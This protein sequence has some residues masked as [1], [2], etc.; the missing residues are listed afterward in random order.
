MGA[1]FLQ[2]ERKSFN[3]LLLLVAIFA[4]LVCGNPCWGSIR[5]DRPSG[6]VTQGEPVKLTVHLQDE[7]PLRVDVYYRVAGFRSYERISF[8]AKGRET[9]DITIPGDSVVPPGVEFYVSVLNDEGETLTSPRLYAEYSPYRVEV[10]L[11][12]PPPKVKLAAPP[13]NIPITD[14]SGEIIFKSDREVVKD[15]VTVLVDGTDVTALAGFSGKR[16]ILPAEVLRTPGDHTI[17]LV[18]KEQREVVSEK[19]WNLTV[20]SAGGEKVVKISSSGGIS[21]NYSKELETPVDSEDEV[22]SGNLSLR[23]AMEAAGWEMAWNGV[24]IQYVKDSPGDDVTISSGFY[25]TLKKAEQ[26]I[27]YGDISVQE[28]SLTAPSFARRGIQ[29]KLKVSDAEIHLFDVSTATVSGWN[30]GLGGNGRQVYG[31]SVKMPVG[32]EGKNPITLVFITGENGAVNGYNAAGTQGPSEGDVFGVAFTGEFGDFSVGGELAFS[33]YDEDTTSG[34]GKVDD[35]SGTVDLGF[36][37]GDYSLSFG[38]FYYGPDFASIANPN[39]TGDREGG[40]ASV[41]TTYGPVSVSLTLNRTW[42]NVERDSSRPIVY[43]T[44]G[45]LSSS[46]NVEGWPGVSFSYSLSEQ[47][48]DNE[49]A[50]SSE[51]NN[52]NH[53]YSL[54]LSK[55]GEFWSA[56]INGSVSRLRDKAGSFGSASKSLSLSGSLTPWEGFSISPSLSY[57]GSRSG[58]VTNRTRLATLSGSLPFIGNTLDASFQVSYTLNDASDGSV[59]QKTVDGSFRLALNLQEVVK[60]LSDYGTAALALSCNY[61][62]VDDDLNPANSGED[63]TVLLTINVSAPFDLS[64]GI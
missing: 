35:F 63:I 43:S 50:G 36:P 57:T 20:A 64:F 14:L 19:S 48:S 23:F 62:K 59:D 17:T 46:F 1:V 61:R 34:G 4:L 41:S 12:R 25:F 7:K 2:S 26:L 24:N 40:N 51:V 22:V 56:G 21:F 16:V 18:F 6:H 28:T 44:A 52:V 58:G 49:P 3:F 30:S 29:A 5:V 8:N 11:N 27:E 33:S 55:S 47:K 53:T 38:Y 37:V 45:T 54:G 31:G 42:D 32:P 15:E 10:V 60:G 13:A 9:I 39:F